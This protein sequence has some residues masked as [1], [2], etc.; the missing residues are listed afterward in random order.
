MDKHVLRVLEL[1]AQSRE[2]MAAPAV[3]KSCRK[4]AQA[5]LARAAQ[6]GAA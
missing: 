1:A 6:W 5:S 2:K 3:T 4:A